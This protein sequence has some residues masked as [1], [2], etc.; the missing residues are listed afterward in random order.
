MYHENYFPSSSAVIYEDFAEAFGRPKEAP[1]F[2]SGRL[3]RKRKHLF[4]EAEDFQGRGSTFFRK[5]KT[6]KE[7][8]APFFG[9]GRLSRKRKHLFRKT[10]RAL[11]AWLI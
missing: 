7:E 9:S 1:F 8:E 6:F 3:L 5:R 2:G 4:S 10:L 11:I